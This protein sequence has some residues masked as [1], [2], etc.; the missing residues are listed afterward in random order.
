[1]G[2]GNMQVNGKIDGVFVER[3]AGHGIHVQDT[4]NS[5]TD[6]NLMNSWLS[7]SAGSGLMLDNAAGWQVR[8]HHIYG[9]G[10][11]SYIFFHITSHRSHLISSPHAARDL[12]QPLLCHDHQ[13]QL[14]RRFRR[15]WKWKVT[16]TLDTERDGGWGGGE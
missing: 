9:V 15:E 2:M 10:Q 5:I 6:W 7:T 13:R 8:N 3:S 14:H 16:D 4:G 11:V 12:C 1:M